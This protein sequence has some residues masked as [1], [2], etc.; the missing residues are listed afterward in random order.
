M[1]ISA[2]T[3]RFYDNE[4]LFSHVSRNGQN[5]RLFSEQDLEWVS[6]VQ[7]LRGTGMPLAEIKRYIELC[8]IGDS[9]I[10]ERYQIILKQKEKAEQ[11]IVAMQQRMNVLEKKVAHYKKLIQNQ[12][13]D[14]WNPINKFPPNTEDVCQSAN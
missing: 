8:K 12:I 5:V 2:H 4:G 13:A 1:K 6:L 3:L 10:E 7:C 14:D 9:T 11:E